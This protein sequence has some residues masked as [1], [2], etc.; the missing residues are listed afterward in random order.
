MMTMPRRNFLLALPAGAL[1]AGSGCGSPPAAAPAATPVATPRPWTDQPAYSIVDI[2]IRDGKAFGEYVAGHTPTIA[3]VGGRF[4]VAGAMPKAVEGSWPARRMVIHQ[5]PSA[6]VFIDWYASAAYAPWK[7]IRHGAS[8]ANVILV[9]GIA[10]S[11]PS[12]EVAPAFTL[13][14]IDVRD[15]AGFGRYV[16]GHM[17][18]LRAAGGVFLVAGGRIEVIEG[19]WAPKRVV[20][21]RWP[22]A[23]T[24]QRW[25]GSDDYR[26]WRDLR[27]SVSQANVVIAEGL[28][29]KGKGERRMP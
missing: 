15:G 24:F 7:K 16:Q 2:D 5:W 1:L 28:S 11:P 13:V 3:A 23:A 19:T 12:P 18:G 14:D 20:L 8:S 10:G 29:E 27:H 17:P 26:P 4:L 25:Y 22:D 6:Q 21:H 9:Q